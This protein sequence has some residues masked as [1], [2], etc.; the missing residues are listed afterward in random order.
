[1]ITKSYKITIFLL[2]IC[3]SNFA[4]AQILNGLRIG[5]GAGESIYW[6]SQMDGKMSFSTYKRSEFNPGYNFQ[7]YKAISNKHE[8]GFR[9]LNTQLWSFKT[10]NTQAINVKV[11]EFA[12][13]YQL[14]LNE[15]AKLNSS[16]LKFTHNLVLGLGLIYY[17]SRAYTI[18]PTTSQFVILSSVGNGI[19]YTSSGLIE[20]EQQSALGGV[21]GYNIGYRL[22]KNFSI[23]L[24]NTFSLSS[25]NNIHGNLLSKAKL[26]NNGYTYSALT[27]YLNIT[28][29]VNPLGCPKF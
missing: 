29:R 18:N 15:N 16:Y 24:E 23:Y 8:I 13:I 14:S 7:I 1:M 22:N 10:S 9:Y 25:S 19:E 27:L 5:V 12:V 21:I 4:N 11:N 26:T 2:L 3:V 20:P 17:K 28:S 6:G